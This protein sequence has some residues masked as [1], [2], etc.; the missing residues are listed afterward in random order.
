M[1]IE[2]IRTAGGKRPA[3]MAVVNGQLVN[4]YS[5]EILPGGVAVTNGR[6]AAAAAGADPA[7]ARHHR[8]YDR[9]ARV[10]RGG[11]SAGH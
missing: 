4:V 9:P 3:D 7:A 8:H 10:R 6:I 11:R 1:D 2:L 5:G